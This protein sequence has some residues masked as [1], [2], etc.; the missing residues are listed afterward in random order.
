[1]TDKTYWSLTEEEINKLFR[2]TDKYKDFP[3]VFLSLEVFLQPG[4]DYN[5]FYDKIKINYPDFGEDILFTL[6]ELI[7]DFKKQNEFNE[8]NDYKNNEFFKQH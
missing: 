5:Y 6:N 2:L 3:N 7:I 8:F 4:E 1:M